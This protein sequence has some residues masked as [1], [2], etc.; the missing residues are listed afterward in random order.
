MG[1]WKN[2]GQ[3]N[4]LLPRGEK[5][6]LVRVEDLRNRDTCGFWHIM[7]LTTIIVPVC[8]G[9]FVFKRN[10]AKKRNDEMSLQLAYSWRYG[11]IARLNITDRTT[12]TDCCTYRA[13]LGSTYL[14]NNWCR[15]FQ[16]SFV[17]HRCNPFLYFTP[18]HFLCLVNCHLGHNQAAFLLCSLKVRFLPGVPCTGPSVVV[19]N[20][21]TYK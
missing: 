15:F 16:F 10:R 14:V 2:R 17:G 11:L 13:E 7:N 8:S 12:L 5:R 21:P 9:R 6:L 19:P 18:E 3:N 4:S 20:L 1:T